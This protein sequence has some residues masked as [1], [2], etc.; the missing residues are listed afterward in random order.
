MNWQNVYADFIFRVA[1]PKTYCNSV[2]YVLQ[3]SVYTEVKKV[4]GQG[5]DRS[6]VTP[7]PR[8]FN[9]DNQYIICDPRCLFHIAIR[10][11]TKKN[12][13]KHVSI[14]P[15]PSMFAWVEKVHLTLFI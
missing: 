11:M 8:P 12:I 10:K 14:I 4:A 7:G 9:Y 1:R 13:C 15:P 3:L 5:G 2:V 6:P